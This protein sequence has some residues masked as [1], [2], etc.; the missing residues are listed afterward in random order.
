MSILFCRNGTAVDFILCVNVILFY[1][2]VLCRFKWECCS[3]HS[4]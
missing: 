3:F 4:C 1:V 2:G